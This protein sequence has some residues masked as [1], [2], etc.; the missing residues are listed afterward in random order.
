MPLLGGIA[1]SRALREKRP[2]VRVLAISG[3]SPEDSGAAHGDFTDAFLLKPVTADE[4]LGTVHR[5]V[6]GER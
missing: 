3:L 1:L 2:G 5:L 6:T 4:L